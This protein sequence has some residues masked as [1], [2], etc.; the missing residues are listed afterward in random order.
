MA[1]L[2]RAQ[3]PL[4]CVALSLLFSLSTA[5]FRS[6]DRNE[7]TKEVLETLRD[8]A[9]YDS[10]VM[11]LNLTGPT[12][13]EVQIYFREVD[14]DDVNMRISVDMT[15]RMIWKDPRLAY[16]TKGIP[17]VSLSEPEMAWIPDAFFKK[18]ITTQQQSTVLPQNYLRVFPDGKVI[19][20]TRLMVLFSC[21][22][23]FHRFPHDEQECPISVASYGYTT[24]DLVLKFAD[25]HPIT[26]TA[27]AMRSVDFVVD[28]VV[29]DYCNSKTSTG[30]YSC[31][32]VV[33]Q[34]TRQVHNYILQWYIPVIFLVI[35]AAMSEVVVATEFLSRL[36]LVLVPL[37]TLCMFSIMY[38]VS[39]L[40]TISYSRP[41][42]IFAGISLLVIFCQLVRIVIL[43]YYAERKI[44]EERGE[45]L[46]RHPRDDC[47]ET[48]IVNADL[49][50]KVTI[51][52]IYVLF[53]LAYFLAYSF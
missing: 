48:L 7:A 40:P 51:C 10:V 8:P 5:N 15:F 32:E 42:D 43:H 52:V 31:V 41:I 23:D 33:L 18:A 38:T 29:T 21:D 37:I 17:Y 36:L 49:I 22:M 26:Y 50:A 4:L 14:V 44:K 47:F 27:G 19:F 11:P 13:T 16:N 30:V 46:P 34:L 6:H 1:F 3:T 45:L 35:I 53:L 39:T 20:S 2:G 28:G 25:N 24:E 9:K 12:V